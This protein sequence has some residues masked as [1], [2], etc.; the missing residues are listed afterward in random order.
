M[1]YRKQRLRKRWQ[2]DTNTD[3][4]D[5]PE[6]ADAQNLA[7]QACD[8]ISLFPEDSRYNTSLLW[9]I[10]IIARELDITQHISRAIV[11]SRLQLLEESLHMRH[12]G[13]FRQQLCRLWETSDLGLSQNTNDCILLG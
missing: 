1:V 4:L 6:L 3:T 7:V 11:S 5:L 12:F 13:L 9:P 10:G 8:L 2:Q